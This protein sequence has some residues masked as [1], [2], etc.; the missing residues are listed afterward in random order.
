[1]ASESSARRQ[2]HVLALPQPAI[3]LVAVVRLDELA[4]G[5]FSR[6]KA[7]LYPE[8]KMVPI[9][10][11]YIEILRGIVCNAKDEP[12]RLCAVVCPNGGPDIAAEFCRA[13]APNDRNSSC[14][15]TAAGAL[16]MRLRELG[17]ATK[18]Q[19]GRWVPGEW[20]NVEELARAHG[21][22]TPLVVESVRPG[23][24][25]HM[26]NAAGRH[27]RN[28]T[29]DLG[30]GAFRSVDGGGKTPDGYQSIHVAESRFEM[31]GAQ[32]WNVSGQSQRPVLQVVDCNV[33]IAGLAGN[34]PKLESP[35]VPATS[36]V[37]GGPKTGAA[38]LEI[39]GI[40]VSAANGPINWPNVDPAVKFGYARGMIGRDDT[41]SFTAS[42]VNGLHSTGRDAGVYQLHYARH[43][44]PQ[45]SD[46]QARQLCAMHRALGCTLRVVADLERNPG[47][48]DATGAERRDALALWIQTVLHEG[49]RPRIYCS[50]GFW[51]LYPE[52]ATTPGLEHCDAWLAA[53]VDAMPGPLAGIH[54]TRI[55]QKQGGGPTLPN[56]FRGRVAGI[57]G[58]VDVDVAFGGITA[59]RA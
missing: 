25:V 43:G 1:M 27:W 11:R 4:G 20:A 58:D 41:D 49:E 26:E 29:D 7:K 15:D 38:Q 42:H 6:L 45:D 28:I 13:N 56:R 21:A 10:D 51:A 39:L 9:D 2:R 53:Y 57:R 23:C 55:W 18:I 34:G 16:A 17:V 59:I 8:S 32:L 31:R 48:D 19:A 40:D 46:V 5:W 52:L 30:G 36:L 35:S 14:K 3:A 37:S 24:I 47:A 44:R 22:M 54:V 33:V 12:A 50:P